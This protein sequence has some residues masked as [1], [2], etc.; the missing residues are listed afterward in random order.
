MKKTKDTIIVMII[1]MSM[2]LITPTISQAALQSNGNRPTRYILDD[3]MWK[4]R[5]M[6]QAGGTLGL[7]D[8]IEYENE[9]KYLTS[10]NPNLDIH[11][12]KNTEYGAM[13]ILS[14][15]SYGNPNPIAN[16]E[17][18]T[19]NHTGIY[20]NTWGTSGELVAGGDIT[21]YENYT[22]A[23]QRYKNSYTLGT[24]VAKVGDAMEETY[25]WHCLYDSSWINKTNKLLVRN[26]VGR[27]IFNYSAIREA[28][29]S[30]TRAVIVVGSGV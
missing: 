9:E 2:I 12:Q 17:T 28:G 3:W 29:T 19:G 21:N 13:A 15:S 11:M 25:K 16:G 26:Y 23:M 1:L 7:T 10:N 8:T 6:Q 18:T 27:S 30:I 5:E 20:I 22:M 24:Y 4:V 14:A